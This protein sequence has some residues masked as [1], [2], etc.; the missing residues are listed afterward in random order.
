MSSI[1]I[2]IHTLYS[3]LIIPFE[4]FSKA[5]RFYGLPVI[6]REAFSKVSYY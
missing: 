6:N 3:T 4:E 2:R 1:I 5:S